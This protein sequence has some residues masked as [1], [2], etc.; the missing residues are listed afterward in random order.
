MTASSRRDRKLYR[1]PHDQAIAGVASGVA[2][3]FDIDTTLVR[4]VWVA[5]GV[6]G[7]G[8]VLYVVLWIMLEEEPAN[9]ED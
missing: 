9:L 4:A 7:V 6:G 8:I 3:Y 5:L 1:D 2:K